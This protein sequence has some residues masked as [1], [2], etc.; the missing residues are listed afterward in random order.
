MLYLQQASCCNLISKKMF[1]HLRVYYKSKKLDEN[2][3][4]RQNL[5][6]KLQ[7]DTINKFF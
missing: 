4:R 3:C 1:A 6:E 2:L 7:F 5:G